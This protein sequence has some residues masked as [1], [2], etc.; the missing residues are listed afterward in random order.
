VT[1]RYV[2]MFSGI[3]S[4]SVAWHPLGWHPIAFAELAAAPSRVL[5][6]RWPAVPNVG[7]MTAHDWSQYRGSVDVVVGGPPCQAFSIAGLRR[8]LDDDRGN[9]SLA[10]AKAIHAI[11]PDWAVV[12]NV[13]GWLSM[14]DNAFG[15]MLAA[16]VGADDALRSPLERGRW[17][18][19]GMVAGPWAR[20]AWRILDAQHFGLAQRRARVFVVAGFARWADPAAVLF[21]PKGV[22]RHRAARGAA[23]QS[24]APTLSARP[25]GGGGLGTDFDLDGG[26]IAGTLQASGKAAGSATQQDAESGLLIAQA[27]GGNNTSGPIDVATACNAKGGT[28]RADFESET[29]VTHALRG[30]GFD[31]GEDGTGRGTPLVAV[32]FDPQGSGK[33]TTLGASTDGTGALGTTKIP[34]IAFSC[35]DYGADATDDLAPT[36]RAMGHAESHANAGGQL[37]VAFPISSDAL[38]G[39]GVAVTPSADATGRVRRRDPGL[40]V[41]RDGDPASTVTA[42]RPGAVGTTTAVR[43]LTP[44]ECE[45]LQGFPDGYTRVPLRRYATRPTTKHFAEFPDLYERDADGGWTR[46]MDDGPRYKALGNSKA[47]PVISWVGQRIAAV[48]RTGRDGAQ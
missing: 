37:A 3:E 26:L 1:L 45:R 11:G 38:R 14:P 32:A 15:C 46:F 30:E 44:T 8:G 13:P 23:R 2:S 24:V 48:T 10:F 47:V 19:A 42:A 27:F 43:R 16:L 34:A 12:E 28:G 7:D 9:L 33:Q 39:D 31:A 41:G 6:H 20:V 35:K 22:S 4:A 40:G 17:P 36:L 18:H 29:F 5:A 21:E 25:T